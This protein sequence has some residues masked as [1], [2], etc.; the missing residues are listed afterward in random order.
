MRIVEYT[1]FFS[2]AVG[3]IVAAPAPLASPQQDAATAAVAAPATQALVATG[4]TAQAAVPTR[5]SV[6]AQSD[7]SD[8]ETSPMDDPSCITYDSAGLAPDGYSRAYFNGSGVDPQGYAAD[9]FNS[10]DRNYD[11]EI[12]SLD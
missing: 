11:G 10:T 2:V 8:A 12:I 4:P 6:P 7:Q 9:G 3:W 5:A 1:L